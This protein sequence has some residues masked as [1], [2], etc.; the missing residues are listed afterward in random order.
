MEELNLQ[1]TQ[2]VQ[3]SQQFASVGERIIAHFLDYL[4]FFIYL[5]AITSLLAFFGINT[6]ATLMLSYLPLVFYDLFC[7]NVFH[8]KSFGKMMMNIKV[9]KMDGSQPGFLDYFLRWIFRLVDNLLLL[10]SV[11]VTTIIINGK[12]QRLGDLAAGTTVI[13]IKKKT[14]LTDTALS[15]IPENYAPVFEQARYLNEKDIETIKKVLKSIRKEPY[16]QQNILISYKTKK[17]ITDRLNIHSE[18]KPVEFLDTI[19]L[20]YNYLNT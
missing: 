1:T 14:K 4:I 13:R 9:V 3:I 8:G 12:G 20:D 7:E 18:M 16:T 5:A 11:A 19:I 17:A 6:P 15:E 2:N 10:G